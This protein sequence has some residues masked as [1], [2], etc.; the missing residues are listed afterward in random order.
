[1]AENYR[2][3]DPDQLLA[4]IEQKEQHRGRGK[5][6]IFLGYAE[7][8]LTEKARQIIQYGETHECWITKESL[9]LEQVLLKVSEL[10]EWSK[11]LREECIEY[12]CE[13][14]DTALDFE[15]T[16]KG[17]SESLVTWLDQ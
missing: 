14:V 13:Y 2:R 6:K 11:E 9:S 15:N 10:I 12:D 1:M 4:H 3:P 5:L 17:L 16:L 7:A 8:D